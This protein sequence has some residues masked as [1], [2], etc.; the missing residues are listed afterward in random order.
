[1][2]NI[3]GKATLLFRTTV[4]K[5]SAKEAAIKA[6]IS[7]RQHAARLCLCWQVPLPPLCLMLIPPPPAE[8]AQ[9]LARSKGQSIQAET[10]GSRFS[11]RI[12]FHRDGV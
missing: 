7:H 6:D 5:G 3:F 8:Q 4:H 2:G 10:A 1:L 12:S 11:R 9:R